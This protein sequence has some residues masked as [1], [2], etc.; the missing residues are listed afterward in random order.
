MH[1]YYGANLF[2]P[3]NL[4]A[5]QTKDG[6]PVVI[7]LHPWSHNSGF[8]EGYI[9]S[10]RAIYYD[11]AAQGFLVFAFDQLG[12]GS[13]IYETINYFGHH[14]TGD[15]G[16]SSLWYDRPAHTEW[17][18]LGKMTQDVSSAVDFLLAPSSGRGH[19]FHSGSW[20]FPKIKTTSIFAVGYSLGG[21]VGLHA[22]AL[23]GR[24]AG[25]ASIS[26][27]TPMRSNKIGSRT[28]GLLRDAELHQLQPRLGFYSSE[29][30]D[31]PYDYDDVLA[32]IAESGRPMLVYAPMQD[33]ENGF[34]EVV[35]VVRRAKA[36]VGSKHAGMI[37]LETPD[38][39]NRLDDATHTAIVEWL[40]IVDGNAGK[41]EPPRGARVAA[42][43]C[44][45][46]MAAPPEYAR[47]YSN[48][49]DRTLRLHAW[50]N[51]C[52][53]I[54]CDSAGSACGVMAGAEPVVV[55][56]LSAG[57][58]TTNWNFTWNLQWRFEGG[59]LV[60]ARGKC[61]HAAATSAEA[62]VTAVACDGSKSQEWALQSSGHVVHAAS[63][64][65]LSVM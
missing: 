44:N 38:T 20:S 43:P 33:R 57:P 18:Q 13:R 2:Y 36:A 42:M 61:L 59:A 51:P 16:T 62:V 40:G 4:T 3:K 14:H 47:W 31:L 41:T 11:L 5:A 54:D 25:V 37:T 35:A 19:P 64:G 29:P 46:S 48:V 65:C 22:A 9:S 8:T 58:K 21:T 17:S 10:A 52:L 56:A 27:F 23:D 24:I 1:E 32:L 39:I 28:G 60:E 50:E 63:G 26:G 15:G 55:T 53:T 30:Q 34:E 49:T 12:M 45:G 7:W 6:L